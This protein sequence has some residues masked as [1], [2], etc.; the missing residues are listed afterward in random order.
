MNARNVLDIYISQRKPQHSVVSFFD[1]H[2]TYIYNIFSQNRRIF[3]WYI[4]MKNTH[5]KTKKISQIKEE[6]ITKILLKDITRWHSK[7]HG[8]GGQHVNKRETT[9]EWYFH[10]DTC[11]LLSEDQKKRLHESYH[12]HINHNWVLRLTYQ[13]ERSLHQN[14]KVLEKHFRMLIQLIHHE[15]VFEYYHKKHH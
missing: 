14:K 5:K 13:K 9:A 6:V 3:I 7:S 10:V 12:N 4:Y 15:T 8:H 1:I 11:S 2:S